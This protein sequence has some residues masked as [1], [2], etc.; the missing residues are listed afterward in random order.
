[1]LQHNMMRHRTFFILLCLLTLVCNK[2]ALAHPHAWIDLHS[3]A[4]FNEEGNIT[5]LKMRWLF[6]EFYTEFAM[7]DYKQA[8]KNVSDQKMLLDLANDNLNSLKDHHYFTEITANKQKQDF[9]SI[10]NITSTLEDK[11]IALDF[12]V[13]LATPLNPRTQIVEYRIFDP[14]YYIEMKHTA[15]KS[16]IFMG[17]APADCAPHLTRPT[18]SIELLGFATSLDKNDTA[19]DNLGAAFAEMVSIQCG[20]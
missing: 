20:K 6:D 16:I 1:M 15:K 2:N 7:S 9:S 10:K 3:T 18:P 14:S 8:H 5:A 4:V 19:P 11:R 12:T 13:V 17:D